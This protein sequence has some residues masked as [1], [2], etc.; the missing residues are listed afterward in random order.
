MIVTL[1]FGD[2]NNHQIEVTSDDPDEAVQEARDWVEDNAWFEA[3][4]EHDKVVA[5]VPMR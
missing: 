1:H 3:L 2:G 5:S 4:D